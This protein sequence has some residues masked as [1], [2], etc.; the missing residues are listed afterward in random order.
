MNEQDWMT[1]WDAFDL[2]SWCEDNA[3]RLSER[4][5][6]LFAVACCRSIWPLL[7]G[8]LIRQAVEVAE[9][10]AD[11]HARREALQA[12]RSAAEEARR[13]AEPAGSGATAAREAFFTYGFA[14]L[15]ERLTQEDF[16]YHYM[17]QDVAD[18][19]TGL[20]VRAAMPLG[21]WGTAEGDAVAEK[22]GGERGSLECELVREIFCNPLRPLVIAHAWRTPLALAIARTAYEERQWQDLPVLAD[23]LEEGGC[24]DETILSHCRGPGPHVRGCWV[25]DALLSKS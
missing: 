13:A 15:A 14:L 12:S 24:R 4:K 18:V 20:A 19:I 22:V 6:R 23:V 25:V 10:F 7:T 16:A 17:A 5:L 21:L 2:L 11:H 8:N 3:G 9:C 1:W